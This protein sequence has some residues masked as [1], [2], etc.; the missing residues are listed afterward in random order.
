MEC[1]ICLDTFVE[2]VKVRIMPNC[3]HIFH[4]ACI[5]ESVKYSSAVPKCPLCNSSLQ[6]ARNDENASPVQDLNDSIEPLNN[7]PRSSVVRLPNIHRNR[8]LR[9]R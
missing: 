6:I 8:R 1:S 3:K 9:V 5:F 4:S 2:G 7:N